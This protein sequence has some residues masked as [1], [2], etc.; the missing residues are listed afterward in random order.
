MKK[1]HGTFTIN[2]IRCLK[3]HWSYFRNPDDQIA[4]C[5][6]WICEQQV[7]EIEVGISHLE[8]IHIAF[9]LDTMKNTTPKNT[10]IYLWALVCISIILYNFM[11]RNYSVHFSSVTQLCSTFC[12]PM[13]CS[14]PGFPVHHQLLEFTQT[15]ESM[16]P[17]NHLIFC[18]P[19]PPIFNLFQQQGLFQ[20]VSS[21]Y[22]LANLLEF[23]LQHQSFQWIFRTNFL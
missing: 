19:S 10:N 7:T 14:T 12:N 23:Q 9:W 1:T 6:V 16:M 3:S 17:S 18:S 2:N 20:W 13:N 4:I 11:P 21:L 22:Q 15:L 5:C 8:L